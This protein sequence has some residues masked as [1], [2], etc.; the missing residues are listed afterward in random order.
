M[1][2]DATAFLMDPSGTTTTKKWIFCIRPWDTRRRGLCQTS[3]A[4]RALAQISGPWFCPC[5][6]KVIFLPCWFSR[7]SAS[8]VIPSAIQWWWPG[9]RHTGFPRDILCERASRIV[10]SSKGLKQDPWWTP[11]FTLNSSLRLQPAHTLLLFFSY[12]LC[13]SRTSHSSTSNLWR[14][15]QMTRL[16]TWS[17]AFSRSTK[18]KYSV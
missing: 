10:M 2:R 6:P 16:G 17:N 11:S 14:A 4:C 15:H 18:A 3:E 9:H 13:M 1:A 8:V 12:M 7:G 5:W